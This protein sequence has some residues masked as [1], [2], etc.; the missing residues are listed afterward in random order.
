MCHLTHCSLDSLWK[1]VREI[2]ILGPLLQQ[3]QRCRFL[4]SRLSSWSHLE[5][6]KRFASELWN[7]PERKMQLAMFLLGTKVNQKHTHSS[8]PFPHLPEYTLLLPC[9]DLPSGLKSPSQGQSSFK[10]T[11]QLLKGGETERNRSQN[12][13]KVIWREIQLTLSRVEFT[14]ESRMNT[15]TKKFPEIF[16]D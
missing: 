2:R 13:C 7:S 11:S 3:E 14:K 5:S 6:G 4:G 10:D 8:L 16:C 9:L 1:F 12:E 15:T